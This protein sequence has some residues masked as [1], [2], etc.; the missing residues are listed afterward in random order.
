LLCIEHIETAA[1]G[2]FIEEDLGSCSHAERFQKTATIEGHA[3]ET[4]LESEELPR[5]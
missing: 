1:S 4:S 2:N 3:K 5:K